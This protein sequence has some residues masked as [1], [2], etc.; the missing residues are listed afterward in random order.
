[1]SANDDD[2]LNEDGGSGENVRRYL[3]PGEQADDDDSD[4]NRNHGTND[5]LDQI[6]EDEDHQFHIDDG[7]ISD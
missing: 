1:M 7:F 2:E 3:T 4:S 5:E 6:M